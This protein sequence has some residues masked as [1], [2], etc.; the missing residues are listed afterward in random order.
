M[1]EGKN[2]V[3][4][5][6]TQTR[7]AR[8]LKR[9]IDGDKCMYPGCT[10]TG[11]KYRS[12]K[13]R[14][15]D[16]H[17]IDRKKENNPPDGSNHQLMCHSCNCK[18]DPAGH[19]VKRRYSF[20]NDFDSS[21]K[22]VRSWDG[23]EEWEW[24]GKYLKPATMKKNQACEPIFRITAEELVKKYGTIKRKDLLD[25]C[26]EKSDCSQATGARYLDKMASHFGVLTYDKDP[27]TGEM[28]VMLKEGK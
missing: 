6:A 28:L 15:F 8:D 3:I 22:K 21:R 13:K 10:M 14:D 4:L 24:Q 11:D 2:K 18:N 23:I 19:P 27:I 16:L 17:H 25:A 12:E 5:T 1:R 20:Q 9:R 26:C 7:N